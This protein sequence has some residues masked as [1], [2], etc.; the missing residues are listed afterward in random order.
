MLPP[1]T[2]G[3][4]SLKPS[5]SVVTGASRAA[6]RFSRYPTPDC[7]VG[8]WSIPAA[9]RRGEGMLETSHCSECAHPPPDPIPQARG[10]AEG[11]PS[12]GCPVF[13]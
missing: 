11:S 8:I 4:W 12:G 13:W 6:S 2:P 10:C 5:A 1:V 7:P 9:A 3:E